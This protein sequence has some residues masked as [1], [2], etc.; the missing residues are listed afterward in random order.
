[1][2]FFARDTSLLTST[3]FCFEGLEASDDSFFNFLRVLN[4]TVRLYF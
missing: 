3:F 1:M 2:G 4:F